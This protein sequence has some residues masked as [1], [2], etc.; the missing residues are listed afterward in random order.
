VNA[1]PVATDELAPPPVHS[2]EDQLPTSRL[3]SILAPLP[4][5]VAPQGPAHKTQRLRAI[6]PSDATAK[7][8]VTPP[9]EAWRRVAAH[10]GRVARAVP[11]S[12]ARREAWTEKRIAVACA[13][14][15]LALIVGAL[16]LGWGAVTSDH[17]EKLDHVPVAVAMVVSRAALAIATM[18]VGYGLL[19]VGE[20]TGLR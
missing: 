13:G 7:L 12:L 16:V 9:R 20:R 8:A 19:R 10:L 6:S 2:S 4:P 1:G 5:P 15:G 11:G 18:A 14:T 17:L 3:Q